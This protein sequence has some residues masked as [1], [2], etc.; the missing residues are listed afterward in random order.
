MKPNEARMVIRKCSVIPLSTL[1]GFIERP[2]WRTTS[3]RVGA[4]CWST[5]SGSW[6]RGG[7]LERLIST[8]GFLFSTWLGFYHAVRGADNQATGSGGKTARR[9]AAREE[10]RQLTSKNGKTRET[11]ETRPSFIH[12][13]LLPR[14]WKM[15][16][17]MQQCLGIPPARHSMLT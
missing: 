8:S 12:S 11:V 3:S 4:K 10:K 16:G 17:S 9:D 5:S 2:L 1:A 6:R 7:A 14:L 13:R 15:H